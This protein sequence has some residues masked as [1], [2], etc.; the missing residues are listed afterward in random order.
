MLKEGIA[1]DGNTHFVL[2]IT[3][4]RPR[5]LLWAVVSGLYYS[6]EYQ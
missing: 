6:T 3:T 2:S 4:Y 5:V 1:V